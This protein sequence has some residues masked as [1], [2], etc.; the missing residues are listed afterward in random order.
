MAKGLT[1]TSD[2]ISLDDDGP[3]AK[4]ELRAVDR[5]RND[6]RTV[7]LRED[8]Y[9]VIR[10]VMELWSVDAEIGLVRVFF[11]LPPPPPSFSPLRTWLTAI[12]F[13]F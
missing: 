12:G 5:A 10:N 6:P 11:F 8:I 13:G 7:K 1:R 4:E 9:A 3:E 2:F